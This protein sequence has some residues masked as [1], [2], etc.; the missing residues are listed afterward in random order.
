MENTSR[1]TVELERRKSSAGLAIGVWC[2]A[3]PR[4]YSM[5][6]IA[7]IWVSSPGASDLH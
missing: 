4:N 2:F 6:I 1:R 5:Q 7:K 3:S